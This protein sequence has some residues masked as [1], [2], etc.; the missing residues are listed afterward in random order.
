M[1]DFVAENKGINAH[2]NKRIITVED[3]LNK[4]LDG[5][6]NEKL[7]MLTFHMLSTYVSVV[8]D[9]CC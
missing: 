5:L 8:V 4:K 3:N 7:F 1:D 9:I 2:S 6:K